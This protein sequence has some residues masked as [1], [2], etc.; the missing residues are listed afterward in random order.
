MVTRLLFSTHEACHA[1][2]SVCRGINSCGI[3][4]VR[5]TFQYVNVI[6]FW[7]VLFLCLGKLLCSL[8]ALSALR[9]KILG[10]KILVL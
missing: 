2:S 9:S 3:R 10:L 4:K 1:N 8:V 7:D 6:L 5:G